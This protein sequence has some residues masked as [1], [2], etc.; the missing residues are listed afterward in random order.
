MSSTRAQLKTEA[1]AKIL[2]GNSDTTAMHLRE[3]EF[4]AIDGAVNKTDDMNIDG[5]YLGISSSRVD[6]AF[7][8]ALSPGGYF[9]RDDGTWQ[10]VPGSALKIVKVTSGASLTVDTGITDQY[11]ITAL[12]ADC[13]ITTTGTPTPGQPL[14]IRILDNGASHA[15]I[16]NPAKFRFENIPAPATTTIG[17]T[18]YLVFKYNKEDDIWD[19]ILNTD[20]TSG[21][22]V[23]TAGIVPVGN[24]TGITNSNLFWNETNKRLGINNSTPA[25][26]LDILS[27]TDDYVVLVTRSAKQGGIYVDGSQVSFGSKTNTPVTF[28]TNDG[29]NQFGTYL[30]LFFI[31]TG[32][33]GSSGA[34]L[35]I[36]GIG[37]STDYSI[38]CFQS[39]N[40]TQIFGV[41]DDGTVNYKNQFSSSAT[42]S[43]AAGA[44]AGISPTINIAGTNKAGQIT[45]TT[46]LSTSTNA[47]VATVTFSGSFA[48]PNGC[49]V[50]LSNGDNATAVLGQ[51]VNLYTV[52]GTTTF[53][54]KTN[55]SQSLVVS[56]AYKINYVV[57]GY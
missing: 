25:Y 56:T 4:D 38:Q 29:S 45:L 48:F 31:G 22:P 54:I 8:N 2:S 28:F 27:T 9:L 57:E 47:I 3:F 14:I 40:S 19:C 30:A 11:E 41:Q 50:T 21:G 35:H 1:N 46:G 7:I 44:G 10:P 42:P 34:K 15:L 32:L 23:I 51:V 36:K 39:D 6:I 53:Q 52:G 26:K 12:A 55:S 33:T 37:T 17:Q 49:I 18:C 43:I 24:G 20:A 16:F 5:G 13:S